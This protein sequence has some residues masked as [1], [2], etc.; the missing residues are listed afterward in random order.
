MRAPKKITSDQSL[1]DEF[2]LLRR[3]QTDRIHTMSATNISGVQPVNLQRSRGS[4]FPTKEIRM[5][6]TSGISVSGVSY[7]YQKM[8]RSREKISLQQFLMLYLV[9]HPVCRS[10][11]VSKN[12]LR[13]TGTI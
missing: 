9:V 3:F 13:Q 2:V 7:S 4:V 10:P 1:F 5:R 12:R 11:V 6:H 8:N